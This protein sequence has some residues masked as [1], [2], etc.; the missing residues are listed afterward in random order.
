MLAR[1]VRLEGV[2]DMM[3]PFLAQTVRNTDEFA[4]DGADGG[5]SSPH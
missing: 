3:N 4:C 1:A 5:L 2:K